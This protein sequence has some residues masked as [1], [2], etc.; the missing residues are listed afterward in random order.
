MRCGRYTEEETFSRCDGAQV[1]RCLQE[2]CGQDYRPLWAGHR[3][4]EISRDLPR[5]KESPGRCKEFLLGEETACLPPCTNTN[6][7][8]R[9]VVSGLCSGQFSAIETTYFSE[10]NY[11]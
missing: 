5:E 3:L 11:L 1:S 2:C 6:V 8:V 10:E 9:K 4:E 7:K